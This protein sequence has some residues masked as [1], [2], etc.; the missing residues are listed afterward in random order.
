MKSV[1]FEFIRANAPELASLG[2]LAEAYARTDP[3][4]SLVK[5][6]AFAE[7]VVATVYQR[8]SL[9]W[10]LESNL[11]DLI[12]Q[13]GF[14]ATVPAVIINKLHSLRIQGNKAAH[15]DRPSSATALWI[16]QEAYDL[17]RWLYG[18][19]YNGNPSACAEF[20]EPEPIID[21]TKREEAKNEVLKK[22]A[23][24]EAQMQ[25]L[26]AELES[27]RSK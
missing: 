12:G 1:N 20:V 8:L 2:A 19:F 24:Q 5:L 23:A 3:A 14:R 26:L 27:T 4:S 10:P 9:P 7:R 17:S 16:L 21:E 13:D 22:L 11:F 15:G 18:T 6:R 25:T